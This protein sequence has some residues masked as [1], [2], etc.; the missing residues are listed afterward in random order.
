MKLTT[1]ELKQMIKEEMKK[2]QNESIDHGEMA[3]RYYPHEAEDYGYDPAI[4]A[5]LERY[6][7][8]GTLSKPLSI[9]ADIMT[10]NTNTSFDDIVKMIS[11]EM[12]DPFSGNIAPETIRDKYGRLIT[13]LMAAMG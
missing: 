1:K 7:D 12:S 3:Q 9:V 13:D 10:Q 2:I 6:N 5:V 4:N 8:S 11:V